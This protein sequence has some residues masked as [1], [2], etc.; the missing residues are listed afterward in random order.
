MKKTN[1]PKH[2]VPVGNIATS[3]VIVEKP[4]EKIDQEGKRKI[5]KGGSFDNLPGWNV[6]VSVVTSWSRKKVPGWNSNDLVPD[7]K[8]FNVT[9]YTNDSLREFDVDDVVA[10]EDLAEG[11]IGGDRAMA[12]YQALG[13]HLVDEDELELDV[14]S[15]V[16]I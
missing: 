13:M 10:F 5:G 9:V 16:P 2:L 6:R 3:A 7:T 11:F 4:T 12:Y 8:E 14:D 1:Y 15:E